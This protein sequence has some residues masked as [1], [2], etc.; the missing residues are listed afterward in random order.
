VLAPGVYLS[1]TVSALDTQPQEQLRRNDPPGSDADA[2]F[3]A[4]D[5]RTI[6][7]GRGTCT[8]RVLGIH[9]GA[10]GL[11]IQLSCEGEPDASV[12]IH[13]TSATRVEEVLQR[14]KSQPPVGRPLEIIDLDGP[15]STPAA[16]SLGRAGAVG[17]LP[18]SHDTH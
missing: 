16:V 2:W 3:S 4:L 14:L 12:V 10:D 7:L 1:F 11:W 17:T 18:T 15:H 9:S 5:D 8:A 13:V 6:E